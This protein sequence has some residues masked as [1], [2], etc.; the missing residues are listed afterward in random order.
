MRSESIVVCTER[1]SVNGGQST[2]S[3]ASVSFLS[4][5]YDSFWVNWMA[6]KWSWCIFQ[7]AAMIGLRS[8]M[9]GPSRVSMGAGRGLAQRLQP[10]EVALLDE[11]ERRAATGAHVVDVGGEPELADRRGAVA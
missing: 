4:S 1:R 5:R 3:T 7:F 9:P 8:V 10:R 11:L 2:T 6:T